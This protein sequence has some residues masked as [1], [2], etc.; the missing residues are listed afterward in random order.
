MIC[1]LVCGRFR[2]TL[3][4]YVTG[5]AN[6]LANSIRI[7]H[8]E[9][10]DSQGDWPPGTY[11]FADIERLIRPE[12]RAAR[13]LAERFEEYPERYRVLN[14]PRRVLRR[15]PML[16]KLYRKG[17][18]AFNVHRPGSPMDEIRFPVFIKREHEH[19]TKGIELLHDADELNQ[20][21]RRLGPIDRLRKHRLMITEYCDIA[22]EQGQFRKYAAMRLGEQIIPRHILLSNRW[23]TKKPDLI[24]SELC[25]EEANF[26]A[27]AQVHEGVADAFELAGIDYGRIDY[28]LLN[29]KIQVWEINTNPRL[30]PPRQ[31]ID[32]QRMDA[33]AASAEQIN[34][35]LTELA[36]PR[37][38]EG[39]TID[40]HLLGL[41]R[42]PFLGLLYRF[43]T[44]HVRS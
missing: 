37:E 34:A 30:V 41:W 22:D 8:Y 25:K 18:N 15:F 33:Q 24:T 11:V 43:Y 26:V 23:L 16:R 12:L 39:I 10:L 17:I 14:D 40:P 28:G 7:L 29:G 35:T 27:S 21:M 19:S 42:G 6:H 31:R 1:F 20:A 9:D 13:R 32:T 38:G 5:W 3:D 2:Y 44:G 4:E 36:S